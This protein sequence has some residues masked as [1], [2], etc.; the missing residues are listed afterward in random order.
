MNKKTIEQI[1]RIV[2]SDNWPLDFN[3]WPEELNKFT[4]C[5][6]FALG[7]PIPDKDYKLFDG[8]K[9]QIR[10]DIL[11]FLKI[12]NLEWREIA[13]IQEAKEDEIIIQG[14][15]FWV[16]VSGEDFHVIRRNLN[17]MW[18]HKQGWHRAPKIIKNPNNLHCHMHPDGITCIF[19]VKKRTS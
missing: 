3:E 1:R 10:K 17:G 5:L 18:V 14:Y 2:N 19:A 6:S 16:P 12:M 4:N 11:K 7:I 8:P 15:E 13:N 9:L